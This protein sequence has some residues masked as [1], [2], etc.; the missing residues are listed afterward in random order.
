MMIFLTEQHDQMT[1]CFIYIIVDLIKQM[2]DK[3]LK[4]LTG[5]IKISLCPT[6]LKKYFVLNC[7]LFF[8]LSQTN[9]SHLI[10]Q[11]LVILYEVIF[12]V[13]I[14]EKWDIFN[15]ADFHR[16][17]RKQVNFYICIRMVVGFDTSY[18]GGRSWIYIYPWNQW[19]IQ[20][21]MRSQVYLIQLYIIMFASDLQQVGGFP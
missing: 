18:M 4:D 10:N 2:S 21:P 11:A 12:V 20:P 5:Q 1:N 13:K 7:D 15:F 8:I 6:M 3:E 14:V 19:Q 9:I 17:L 16:I